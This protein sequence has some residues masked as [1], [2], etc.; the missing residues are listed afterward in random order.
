[1]EQGLLTVHPLAQEDPTPFGREA[2]TFSPG[3]SAT[4]EISRLLERTLL[5]RHVIRQLSTLSWLLLV[6]LWLCHVRS[7]LA[8]LEL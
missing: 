3:R 6:V 5:G 4:A 1:M 7:L 2:E 8:I